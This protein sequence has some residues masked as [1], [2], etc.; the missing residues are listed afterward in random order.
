MKI[1]ACFEPLEFDEFLSSATAAEKCGYHRI[2]VTDASLIWR[3]VYVYMTR[4]LAATE[5]CD[6]AS[7]VTNPVTRHWT[8]T[9][10]A[11]AT[12]AQMHPGRVI[13]GIG[14]GESSVRTLGLQPMKSA[15]YAALVPRI[16]ALMAG[17]SVGDDD[18]ELRI[19]WANT[20]VPLM[21]GATGPKNLKLAGALADIVMLQVGGL[22][23]AARWAI[24][25]VRK[26][27]EEAGRNP[28]D[29][30]IVAT[31]D[32]CVSEDEE[33]IRET[34]AVT[35][36]VAGNHLRRVI[37]MSPEHGMPDE[38]I[39]AAEG[40]KAAYDY[41]QHCVPGADQYAKVTGEMIRHFSIVGTDGECL[42]HLRALGEAG[43]DE[44]AVFPMNGRLEQM[45]I[46][47]DRILPALEPVT[48]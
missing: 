41:F 42:A 25:W 14:R 39:E 4:A 8:T 5:R 34:G 29:L 40:T 22:P 3:D 45:E 24:D 44:I 31:C 9:A 16:A 17:E 6:V 7:F 20:R 15:E 13:L 32:L 27:A 35:A 47:R 2:Y 30:Q 1:S 36:V 37:R 12:L 21:L 28:H 23:V 18:R 26:G 19:T 48:S 33:E 10:S 46:V 11:H 38:L 43:V